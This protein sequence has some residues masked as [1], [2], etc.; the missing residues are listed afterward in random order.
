MKTTM[1]EVDVS[2]RRSASVTAISSQMAH[3]PWYEIA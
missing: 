2:E 3:D 1:G